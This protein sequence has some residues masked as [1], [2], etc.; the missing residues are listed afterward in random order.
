MKHKLHPLAAAIAAG[1]SLCA[2]TALAGVTPVVVQPEIVTNERTLI[3]ENGVVVENSNSGSGDARLAQA[4]PDKI[5]KQVRIITSTSEDGIPGHA[6]IDVLVSNAMSEAFSGGLGSVHVK[7]VKNAPYSAEVVSE[8][9]QHLA[10]GNQIS[11]RTT[12]MTYRDSAGRTRQ[13]VRD[14]GGNV[15]TIHINDNVVGTRLM[16]SPAAKGFQAFLKGY[17]SDWES[18]TRLARGKPKRINAVKSG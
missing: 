12:T 16:L 3:I 9:I 13:E 10:D 18:R 6:D 14:A 1:L 15:K 5:N 4:S 11:K 8:K 7:C 17:V 2:T